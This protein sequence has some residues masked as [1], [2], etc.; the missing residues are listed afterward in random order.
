MKN[1]KK[2]HKIHKKSKFLWASTMAGVLVM[3]LLVLAGPTPQ[4]YAADKGTWSSDEDGGY[5]YTDQNGWKFSMDEK[6]SD[7]C[8]L[9]T[10][11]E[12][13][14]GEL[15][16]P[17]KIRLDSIVRKVYLSYYFVISINFSYAAPHTS[18][19]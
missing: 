16:I 9:E 15:N 7:T 3:A 8:V 10:V 1:S 12:D 18:L 5:C 6:N 4:I 13:M 17:T 19:C 2:L 11:P 14:Q